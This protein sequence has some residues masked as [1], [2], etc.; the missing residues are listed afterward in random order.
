[1]L[2]PIGPWCGSTS[3]LFTCLPHTCRRR[4]SRF[5]TFPFLLLFAGP[6]LLYQQRLPSL[7]S[8]FSQLL[9]STVLSEQGAQLRT[10]GEEA[11]ERL[12]GTILRRA[13]G[14]RAS[15]A[16]RSVK[17]KALVDLLKGLRALGLSHHK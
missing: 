11:L 10:S 8:R 2:S 6:P 13:Q 4:R 7:A 15:E 12:S 1:M 14:L 9:G 17:K 5:S 16:K 3:C